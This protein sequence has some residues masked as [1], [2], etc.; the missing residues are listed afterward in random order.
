[1]PLEIR[2]TE[3]VAMIHYVMA[4]Q[5]ELALFL[6]RRKSSSLRKLFED[7]KEVEEN[8]HASRRIQDQICIENLHAHEQA[9]CQYCSDFE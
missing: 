5:S 3:T 4:Q 8:I 7:A 1:M 2:S 6:L 9:E